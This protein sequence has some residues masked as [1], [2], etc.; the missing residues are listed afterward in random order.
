MAQKLKEWLETEVAAVSH[1]GTKWLSEMYFHRQ[2]ARPT[3]ID[4]QYFFTPADGVILGSYEN[5]GADEQLIQV[6]GVN[7]TLKDLM[8]DETLEGKFLVVS[9]FMTF[10]SQHINYIPFT[11]NRVYEELPSLTTF[12]RPMLKVE[13]DLLNG[14]IN[15]EFQEEYLRKNAREVSEIWSH[16]IDQEY[17]I[18]RVA[19]YD[20][21]TFTNIK[22][23]DGL[24]SMPYNQNDKIGS[25]IYGSQCVLVI[26]QYDGEGTCKFT[27]RPEAEVGNYVKCKIDPL[28][29][30]TYPNK[31]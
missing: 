31:I 4:N 1:K 22:Q 5:I 7:F 3:P 15:P 23:F 17:F 8:Q 28:V 26:P 29:K 13:Q 18:V 2:E 20:V 10:Y 24:E 11:G 14:L 9:I 25:I 6:K 16:K 19:D 27:L 30:V 12:N 21:D